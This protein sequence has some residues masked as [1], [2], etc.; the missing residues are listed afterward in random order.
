MAFAILIV[1]R[2]FPGYEDTMMLL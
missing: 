2:E 1:L